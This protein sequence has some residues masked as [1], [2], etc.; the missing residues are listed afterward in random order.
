MRK[1]RICDCDQQDISVV[2]CDGDGGDSKAFEMMTST[3]PCLSKH[4]IMFLFINP[5]RSYISYSAI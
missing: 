4:F 5:N 1:G 3:K 2:I